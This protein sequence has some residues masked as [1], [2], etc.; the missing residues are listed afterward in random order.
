MPNQPKTKARTFRLDEE[1]LDT[2]TALGERLGG[3]DR[4]AVLRLAIR[5]LADA[6]LGAR[7]G[8]PRKSRKSG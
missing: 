7:E 2:L 4:T 8:T 5:R 3:L 1:T 6:E